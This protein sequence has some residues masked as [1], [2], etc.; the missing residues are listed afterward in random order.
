MEGK[1]GVMRGYKAILV[2]VCV[3]ALAAGGVAAYRALRRTV[4]V[5]QAFTIPAGSE[6]AWDARQVAAGEVSLAGGLPEGMRW[7]GSMAR[8]SW[9]PSAHQAGSHRVVLTVE[10]PLTTIRVDLNIKVAGANR[11]PELTEPPMGRATEDEPYRCVLGIRD[12]DGDAVRV[13]LA[14]APKGMTLDEADGEWALSW[15]PRQEHAGSHR[16]VIELSDG[17]RLTTRKATIAVAEVNDAPVIVSTPPRHVSHK[18]GY[19]YMVKATDEEGEPLT[20]SIVDGPDGMSIDAQSGQLTWKPGLAARTAEKVTVQVADARGGKA[21][22]EFTVVLSSLY[23]VAAVGEAMEHVVPLGKGLLCGVS[24]HG[25]KVFRQ[26]NVRDVVSQLWDPSRSLR[27]LACVAGHVYVTRGNEGIDVFDVTQPET[28]RHLTRLEVNLGAYASIELVGDKL[29]APETHDGSLR[30]FSLADPARPREIARFKP[31]PRAAGFSPPRQP[32]LVDGRLYVLGGRGLSVIDARDMQ[33]MR[34]LGDLPIQSRMALGGLVVR[35]PHAYVFANHGIRVFDVATPEAIR[36][37]ATPKGHVVHCSQAALRGRHFVAYG[38]SGVYQYSLDNPLEPRQTISYAN[39][40]P[41][42]FMPG[43]EHDYLVD[44]SGKAE[45]L[46]H[47][48]TLP[49]RE[50]GARLI[51]RKVLAKGGRLYVLGPTLRILDVTN[52]K[53]PKFLGSAR[54]SIGAIPSLVLRGDILFTNS[55]IF[56]VADP[57]KIKLVSQFRGGYCLALHRD[58]T[59]FVTGEKRLTTWDVRDVASPKELT[60]QEFEEEIKSALVH[61]DVLYLG[62]KTG[63]L[64]SYRIQADRSLVP[65][66]RLKL[67]RSEHGWVADLDADSR[68]LYAALYVDGVVSLD[69]RTPEKL[70][71]RSHFDTPGGAVALKGIGGFAYVADSGATIIVDL[72]DKGLGRLVASRPT[73]NRASA[74]DITGSH[75]YVGEWEAGLSVL[76]S[77]LLT[78]ARKSA[79]EF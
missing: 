17:A 39:C 7:D 36:H 42:F 74:I 21:R 34:L 19:Q 58:H 5:Q 43:R 11:A 50:A 4:T 27:T 15:L 38:D 22:Q 61:G 26:N 72:V 24:P 12:P 79:V 41:A 49:H 64:A 16:I 14:A 29:I 53:R 44:D 77:D 73:A 48:L 56:D 63:V 6:F 30:V 45:A 55:A 76:A 52:P 78:T 10:R 20:Y 59:L 35:P 1:G 69:L 3:A 37:V 60:T 13:R 18:A 9:T 8:L 54:C 47:D 57:L 31:E 67:G 51:P 2:A 25:L 71:V 28:I 66:D 75:V 68:F 65:L 40:L 46:S 33:R 32:K 62:L 23:K 70:K